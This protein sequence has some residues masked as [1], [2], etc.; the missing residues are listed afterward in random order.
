MPEC[1]LPEHLKKRKHNDWPFFLRWVP[2]SLNAFGPRCGEGNKGFL[3]WPPILI[4]GHGIARWEATRPSNSIIEIP[5]LKNITVKGIDIYGKE[6]DVIERNEEP[7][8]R[9]F[10]ITLTTGG[11]YSPSAIQEFSDHGWMKLKP[12]FHARWKKLTKTKIYFHRRG[13]RPD[14]EDTY[15][16]WGPY[17]GLEFE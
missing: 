1:A 5:A 17:W 7:R 10:K 14:H 8:G 3:P 9:E 4:S 2:R 11:L 6:W 13:Y 15:Y 16:N 12:E